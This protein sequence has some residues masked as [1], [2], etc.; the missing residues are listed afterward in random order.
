[1]WKTCF[2][3]LMLAEVFSGL[4]WKC[5]NVVVG[6]FRLGVVITILLYHNL[7]LIFFCT[8]N[9]PITSLSSLLVIQRSRKAKNMILKKKTFSRKTRYPLEVKNKTLLQTENQILI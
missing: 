1:M 3:A 7:Y 8:A 9:V 2:E 5:P 6:F 4:H